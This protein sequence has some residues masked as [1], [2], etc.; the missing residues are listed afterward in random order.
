MAIQ[1][2]SGTLVMDNSTSP[3][4]SLMRVVTAGMLLS[5]QDMKASDGNILLRGNSATSLDGPVIPEDAGA[6]FYNTVDSN[7]KNSLA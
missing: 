2:T 1:N 5:A 4:D 6:K 7:A 3:S